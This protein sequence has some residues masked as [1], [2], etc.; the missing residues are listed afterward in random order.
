MRI[1]DLRHSFA[2]FALESGENILTISAALGHASTQMTE[3][4]LHLQRGATEALATRTSAYIL[5]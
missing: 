1:H 2:S 3:R 4:Y 5:A